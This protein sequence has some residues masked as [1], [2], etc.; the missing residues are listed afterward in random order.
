[1]STFMPGWFLPTRL[2]VLIMNHFIV[3]CFF[4]RVALLNKNTTMF[5][6]ACGR[7]LRRN[8]ASVQR[9]LLRC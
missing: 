9:L 8:A 4:S 1:M 3:A 5:L 7:A 2:E 6:T